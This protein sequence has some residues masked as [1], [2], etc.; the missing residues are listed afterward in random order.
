MSSRRLD[1]T[2]K[3]NFTFIALHILFMRLRSI[4]VVNLESRLQTQQEGCV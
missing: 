3:W 1:K 4:L 2:I